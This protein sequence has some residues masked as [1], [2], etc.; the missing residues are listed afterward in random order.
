[1][2]K[3]KG[4]FYVCCPHCG[5]IVSKTVATEYAENKCS[6]GSRIASWVEKGCVMTFDAD[7]QSESYGMAER[8]RSYHEKLRTAQG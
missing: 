4:L 8:I 5:G 2:S 7:E 1:M 3:R 6:C